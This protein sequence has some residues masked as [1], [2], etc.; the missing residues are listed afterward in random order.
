MSEATP[1]APAAER[2][3]FDRLVGLYTSPAETFRSI[4]ARPTALVP[5]LILIVLMAGFFGLWVSKA[6]PV[7]FYRDQ[8][9][10]SSWAQRM[11]PE[12]KEA[13]IQQQA[14]FFPL[15]PV[16]VVVGGGVFY[17]LTALVYLGIFRFLYGADLR[18][19]QSLAITLW[20]FLAVSL[21]SMP[22][23]VL[24]LYLK[25]DWNLDP[26]QVLQA[27]LG[28]FLPA[29]APKWLT[30]LASSIDLFSIW[31]LIL[32][33]IGYGVASR[34]TLGGA[35]PGVMIPWVIYVVG[36]VALAALFG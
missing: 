13:Q 29:T 23:M 1:V 7:T 5:L 30:A 31:T 24:V 3:F 36:K 26:N 17:V 14:R 21:I 8:M 2:G 18:F 11:T 33:A 16:F 12:Q 34:R 10:Q 22:L 28:I 4:V 9:E 35:L 20:T 32:L 15:T 25:G 27:N 19:K 6:D